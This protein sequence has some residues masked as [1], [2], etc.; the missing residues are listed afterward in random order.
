MTKTIKGSIIQL[1]AFDG[2]P[3]TLMARR[4]SPPTPLRSSG[5]RPSLRRSSEAAATP[6][7]AQLGMLCALVGS[8]LW[9][10]LASR[11]GLAVSTSHSIVGATI[12]VGVA[13]RGPSGVLWGDARRGVWSIV[14]SWVVSPFLAGALGALLFSATKLAVL[15]APD[16]HTRSAQP[17]EAAAT[18][19]GPPAPGCAFARSAA[20]AADRRSMSSPP[21]PRLPFPRR[22]QCVGCIL[23]TSP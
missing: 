13:F 22:S 3:D 19:A 11:L 14:L 10:N 15:R 2:Q 7:R 12:G 9:V 16:P 20:A 1:G 18:R 4:T 5:R 21:P 23:S 17:R 6:S 8:S